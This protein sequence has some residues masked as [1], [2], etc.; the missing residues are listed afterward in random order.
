MARRSAAAAA[1]LFDSRA[2][3]ALVIIIVATPL[4]CLSFVISVRDQSAVATIA[5]AIAWRTKRLS[6]GRPE[7]SA[8]HEPPSRW[9]VETSWYNPEVLRV[10]GP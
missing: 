5:A 6:A 3:V 4:A 2:Y 9:D 8:E 1:S 7:P 10:P